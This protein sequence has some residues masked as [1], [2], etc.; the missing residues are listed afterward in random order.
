MTEDRSVHLGLGKTV[1]EY[2]CSIQVDIK[3]FGSSFL[4]AMK[5]SVFAKQM[6]AYYASELVLISRNNIDD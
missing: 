4:I 1:Y 3:W 6:T 5:I 2:Y